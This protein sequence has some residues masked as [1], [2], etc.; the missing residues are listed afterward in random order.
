MI[1][2][3]CLLAFPTQSSESSEL[4]FEQDYT[5]RKKICCPGS[6]LRC[7]APCTAV[8]ARL[9]STSHVQIGREKMPVVSWS[10]GNPLYPNQRLLPLRFSELVS[11]LSYK[12]WHKL[13]L[14]Q[15]CRREKERTKEVVAAAVHTCCW[16]ANELHPP[17][18]W[19]QQ[20]I[21]P[22]SELNTPLKYVDHYSAW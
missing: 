15:N 2:G 17:V 5:A 3:F 11:A 21:I 4:D 9:G 20:A 22:A 10:P 7:A 12:L 16:E 14:A 6:K 1:K 8:A 13:L 19:W 18:S